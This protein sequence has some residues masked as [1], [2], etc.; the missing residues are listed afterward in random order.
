MLSGLFTIALLIAAGGYQ[1]QNFS[2][3][4]PSTGG[5]NAPVG[6]QF[7]SGSYSQPPQTG[8]PGGYGAPPPSGPP[9]TSGGYGS[10]PSGG[11]GGGDRERD[12]SAGRYGMSPQI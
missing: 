9:P 1:A 10:S 5:Y 7:Q 3:P 6:G 4:P 12:R 11:Y 8:A 2:G